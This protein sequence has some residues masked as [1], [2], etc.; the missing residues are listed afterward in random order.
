MRRGGRRHPEAGHRRRDDR[1]V[2][3]A[4]YP[5][6]WQADAAVALLADC[7]IRA[8]AKYGDADGWAPNLALLDGYRV[9]VF[10]SDLPTAREV[11]DGTGFD[12]SVA[13]N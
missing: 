9:C 3:V 2:E 13:E 5:T 6:R 8:V 7:G 1:I 4:N 11:L 12:L 10:A